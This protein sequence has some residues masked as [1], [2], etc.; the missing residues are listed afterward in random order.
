M[1]FVSTF[2]FWGVLNFNNF[3]RQT[4]NEISKFI[5]CWPKTLNIIKEYTEEISL[6]NSNFKN[7]FI[8]NMHIFVYMF[9]VHFYSKL[10]KIVLII[11]TE[12]SGNCNCKHFR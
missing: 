1:F 4:D 2:Y 10:T 6:F 12:I 9:K 7:L 11:N 3:D 5:I 8:I